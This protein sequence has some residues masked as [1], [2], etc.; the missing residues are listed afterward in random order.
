MLGATE[1]SYGMSW[2][3]LVVLAARP[4]VQEKIREEQAAL[5]ASAGDPQGVERETLNDVRLYLGLART[6][7]IRCIYG[8]IGREITKYQGWVIRTF[9]TSH[10]D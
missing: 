10:T 7:Y 3:A 5:I 1:T 9:E 6:V 8:I 4:D 2:A